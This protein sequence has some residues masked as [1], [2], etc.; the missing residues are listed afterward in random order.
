MSSELTAKEMVS[1]SKS[2]FYTKGA[3]VFGLL[4][5]GGYAEYCVIPETLAMPLPDSYTYEEGAAI[6]EVFLTAFQA[7]IL[8]GEL[9]EEEVVLVHAG[10]SGVVSEVIQ[11]AVQ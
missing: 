6:P 10:A 2:S 9:G 5:G 11:L 3:R 8:L 7:L 4:P 1:G